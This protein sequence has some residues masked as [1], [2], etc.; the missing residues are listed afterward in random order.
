MCLLAGLGSGNGDVGPIIENFAKW[1]KSGSLDHIRD[2]VF[3]CAFSPLKDQIDVSEVKKAALAN[4][5][6]S[7]SNGSL[8]I[9]SPLALWAS[10]ISDAELFRQKIDEIV[11]LIHPNEVVKEAVYLHCLAI[12]H[13]VQNP[14]DSARG[15]RAF[16]L[17]HQNCKNPTVLGWFDQA[18][19]LQKLA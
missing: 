3:E 15:L 12:K 8:M 7:I 10:E 16:S 17:A 11:E 18:L 14:Y 4:N 19:A 13:L 9:I 1:I 2:D 5:L 6:E